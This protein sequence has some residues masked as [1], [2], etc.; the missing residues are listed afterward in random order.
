MNSGSVMMQNSS[1]TT[2][3]ASGTIWFGGRAYISR[4][5]IT[6][7]S[8]R[9]AMDR[10]YGGNSVKINAAKGKA[11]DSITAEDIEAALGNAKDVNAG[12]YRARGSNSAGDIYYSVPVNY[13]GLNNQDNTKRVLFD[14][15][16]YN[17]AHIK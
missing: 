3:G 16:I 17:D 5:S 7:S 9:A 10:V 15:Q 2:T 4:N 14:S 11:D 6:D 1:S 13:E 8:L 12:D